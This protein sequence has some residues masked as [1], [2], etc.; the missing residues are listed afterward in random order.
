M[1]HSHRIKHK[2]C[3][4][5]IIVLTQ[6]VHCISEENVLCNYHSPPHRCGGKSSKGE[7]GFNG[8]VHFSRANYD[9]L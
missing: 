3:F 9:V 8:L 6:N 4:F 7:I 2:T 5:N 1:A